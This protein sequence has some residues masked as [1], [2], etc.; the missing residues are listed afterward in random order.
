MAHDHAHEAARE[1][2]EEY[3][4]CPPEVRALL[5]DFGDQPVLPLWS[6]NPMEIVQEARRWHAEQKAYW[7]MRHLRKL[8][9]L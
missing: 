2:M 9:D 8:E 3:D 5:R 6:P 4:M 7:R 1:R